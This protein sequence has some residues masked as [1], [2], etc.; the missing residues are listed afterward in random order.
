MVG[1]E[2]VN[3]QLQAALTS[4]VVIEQAEGVVAQQTGLEMDAAFALLHDHARSRP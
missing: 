2:V 4:R 3:E 1:A